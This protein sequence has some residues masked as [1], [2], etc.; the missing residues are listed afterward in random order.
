MLNI[1]EPK[2]NGSEFQFLRTY[3]VGTEHSSGQKKK[4]KSKPKELFLKE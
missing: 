4:N 2:H 3:V 1:N